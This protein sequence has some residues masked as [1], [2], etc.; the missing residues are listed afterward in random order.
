V[1]ILFAIPLFSGLVV[2]QSAIISRVPLLNGTADIVLLVVIAWA[3]Q[4]RVKN[5]WYWSIIAGV[6]IS[7]ASGLP[8]GVLL[9]AYLL[10]TALALLLRRRVWKAP[11]LAMFVSVFFSTLIVLG[12]SIIARML[13]GINIPLVE[14]FNLIILPSLILNLLLAVPIYAIIRDVANWFYREEIKV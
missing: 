7:I 5:P 6:A 11:I 13:T 14:T 12:L 1:T 3:L 9:A 8:F 4:E 10:A 2:L